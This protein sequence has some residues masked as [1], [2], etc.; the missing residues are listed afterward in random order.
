MSVINEFLDYLKNEK[1]T[2][3]NTVLAYKRDICAFERFANGRG[4]FSPREVTN[5]EVVSYLIQLKNDGKSKGT[6]NRKLA[7]IRSFYNYMQRMGRMSVNPTEDIKSPKID[8]KDLE[9]LTIQEVELL[10]D[11]PD[12]SVKG[13]RDRAILE[14]MYATGIKVSEVIEL[15]LSDMNLHMGFVTC[16]GSHGRARIVPM[17]NM[18]KDALQSYID[19]SRNFLMRGEEV[20]NPDKTFFVNYMGKPFTRQGLWKIM[21]EYGVKSGMEHKITP[22]ILRNSFAVHMIQ[23]GADL[24]SLQELLGHEDI[25]ATQ[26]YLSVTKNRIK[27]VYDKTHPRA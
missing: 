17:G 19:E 15:K 3:D 1:K 7:S 8:R 27:D 20:D 10:L 18:A 12:N 21:K 6:V 23:N 11:Q 13:I 9:F 22:H 25:A 2:A 5:A 14:L 4:I 24:K 26:I 16:S